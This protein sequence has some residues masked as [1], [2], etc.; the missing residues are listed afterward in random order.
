M[1]IL[2]TLTF[3]II[4][5]VATGIKFLG[6]R[7]EWAQNLPPKPETSLTL[8][9]AA[10][11]WALSLT[12]HFTILLSLSYG[13]R[14]QYFAPMVVISV[15]I[16]SL[17]FHFGISSALY[18][19]KNVPPA[20][21][22]VKQAGEN[23]L[24]LSNNLNRNETAV[25]LLKGPADPL[26]PR[27]T[28]IPNRPLQFFESTSNVNIDLPPIP[29]GDDTPWFLKSVSIDIRLSGAQLYNR[30]VEGYHSYFIYAVALIFLLSSLGFAIKFSVWPL[31]DLFLGALAFRGILAVETFLNT[32]EMQEIIGSY[33]DNK[34]PVSMAVPAVFFSFGLLVNIYAILVYVIKRRKSDDI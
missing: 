13:A 1:S 12:M 17:I 26:G 15:T 28:A 24:I 2:F 6:L 5:L 18:Q 7:V 10:A 11:H 3:L 9:I 34:I 4:F 23:G 27:V 22:A 20:V 25:I 14:R 8:L 16:L 21:T 32:P 19:W 33:L 29:F 30:F 31:A